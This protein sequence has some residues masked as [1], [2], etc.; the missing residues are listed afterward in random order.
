MRLLFQLMVTI[1]LTFS[2][3]ARTSG[4]FRYNLTC[5]DCKTNYTGDACHVVTRLTP[6]TTVYNTS[7]NELL[8]CRFFNYNFE[9]D[10]GYD[11]VRR[12]FVRIDWNDPS[13]WK[14]ICSCP[15]PENSNHECKNCKIC[16]RDLCNTGL[17][18]GRNYDVDGFYGNGSLNTSSAEKRY[19]Q[20]VF[21]TLIN[22]YRDTINGQR[23]REEEGE[24]EGGREKKEGE[25]GRRREKEGGRERKEEERKKE[26]ERGKEEERKKEGERGKEEERK[27]EGEKGKEEER[28]KE[29]ERGKEEERK[30]EGEK[31]GG[32]ERKGGRGREKEEG[33]RGKEEE[34]K[35]EGERGKEEER[36]KEGE[37]G[38]EEERKKEGE[39]GKEE[40]RKKEGE[41]GKEEERKKEGERGK[42]EERKKEGERGKEEE[43]KRG[44]EREEE[45]RKRERERERGERTITRV[46][47]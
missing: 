7:E 37:R 27:K 10:G 6:R 13:D 28:K 18:T 40:E 35:K 17:H 12:D 8:F 44:E 1:V 9:G 24:K 43:R 19:D 21:G 31:E 23:E 47:Y 26:G 14:Y 46:C 39:R 4:Y 15:L 32:R 34:R 36:K 22:L 16:Q 20:P 29:G 33:E 11:K 3:C 25:R 2:W 30:K 5:Y 41:R 38:K 45:E 42:E